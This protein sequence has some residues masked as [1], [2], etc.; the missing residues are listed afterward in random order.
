MSTLHGKDCL[1]PLGRGELRKPEEYSDQPG[2]DTH[3]TPRDDH[4][5]RKG[6]EGE[7]GAEQAIQKDE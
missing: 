7:R 3:P 6:D 5:G 2:Q 4:A 1:T